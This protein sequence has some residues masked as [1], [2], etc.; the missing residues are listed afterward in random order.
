MSF[1]R[2]ETPHHFHVFGTFK[3]YTEGGSDELTP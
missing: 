2:A 3:D 1:G